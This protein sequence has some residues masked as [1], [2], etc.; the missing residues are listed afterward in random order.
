MLQTMRD[1]LQGPVILGL[2][3]ILGVAFAVW[4]ISVRQFSGDSSDP[5]LASVG[6]QKITM[7]QFHQ[8]YDRSYQYLVQM[9]GDNFRPDSID[10]GKFRVDVLQNMVNRALLLQYAHRMGYRTTDA[11][12]FEAINQIP[13]F[14]DGEH[15]S[16]DVYKARLQAEGRSAESFESELRQ[17]LTA[18]QLHDAVQVTAFVTPRQVEQQ[19]QMDHQTRSYRLVHIDPASEPAGDL[20]PAQIQAYYN[21]HQNDFRTPQ[22]IRLSYV[23]FA[24]DKLPVVAPPKPDVLRM[25]YDAQKATEFAITEE[26]RAAHILITNGADPAASQKK[27]A[28]LV[29]QIRSGG[30]FAALARQYS[31]DTSSKDNGGDLGWERRGSINPEFEQALFSLQVGA[32]SEPVKTKFGWDIIKLV[33]VHPGGIKPFEDPDVQRSLMAT[34]QKRDAVKRF[35]DGLD[36]LSEMAFENP[37]SLDPVA[38]ALGLAVQS[39]DWITPQGGTGLAANPALVKA[40]FAPDVFQDGDNSKPIAVAPKDLVVIRRLDAAPPRLQALNE[41]SEDIRK[42]LQAQHATDLASAQGQQIVDGVKAG[43]SLDAVAAQLKL[44]A[45][46]PKTIA[47]DDNSIGPAVTDGLFRLPAPTDKLPSLVA[48]TAKDGS[49]DVVQ[50]LSVGTTPAP[51]VSSPDE[52]KAATALSDRFAGETFDS[53]R[54]LMENK[55]KVKVLAS[56]TDL[57]GNSNPLE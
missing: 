2:L 21:A 12:L 42:R 20:S 41:V 31:E 17:E 32:V 10:Q 45:Q 24:Q 37:T 51:G 39:T 8:E 29:Q 30:D 5:T 33:D 15:F 1:R 55:V 6:R 50:L 22:R 4:G 9:Q 27:A 18:E 47:R 34:Y 56:P 57:G 53:Y 49:V 25:I 46:A 11:S 13:R 16:V 36:K 44:S 26:R 23:E 35:Q 7:A 40:A 14:Q 3:V 54:A 38:K 52:R 48:V 19:W 28:G 43:H